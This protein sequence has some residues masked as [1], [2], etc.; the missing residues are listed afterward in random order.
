MAAEE[1][2]GRGRG[3]LTR[4]V[5]VLDELPELAGSL[6]GERAAS[7]RQDLLARILMLSPGPW[8]EGE[9]PPNVKDGAGLLVLD[10]LLIRRVGIDRRYGAELLAAGD[11]LRPW[12]REDVVAS[13]VRESGWRVLRRARLAL[14][15]LD[16]LRRAAPYPEVVVALIDH[17]L[18]RS[19]SLAVN[20]AIVHQPRVEMRLQ[21][22]LW[23]LADR[24][25]SVSRDGVN[26]PLRL[27][28]ALLA[29][30]VA[31]RRPT[32]SAAVSTLQREGLIT[33]ASDGWC[34][35]GSPPGELTAFDE[36]FGD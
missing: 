33:R 8:S 26:L 4:N 3:K 14:L 32:V 11:L 6:A 13:V 2:A 36:A 21:M 12:Q 18:R 22:V 24:W 30:L 31:A 34:L 5:R 9:W 28:H 15:D 10:G 17:T 23:H 27:T 25:G 35:H 1:R 16:F 19:R 7:A 20:M 29:D